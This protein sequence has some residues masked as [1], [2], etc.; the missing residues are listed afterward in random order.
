MNPNLGTSTI[1]IEANTETVWAVLADE[2]VDLAAWSP[3]V[4][5]SGPNPATPEGING[6]RYGGRVAEVEGLGHIDVRLTAYDADART[7]SYTVDAE[8]I[9]PFIERLSNTWTVTADGVD[10]CTVLTE[11]A[12]TIAE[13]MAGNE[14]AS[15]AVDT[16]LA[17]GTGASTDLKTY[18]EARK[19]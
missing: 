7:L 14:Q 18:I 2:F 9:P 1:T 5:S 15:K 8:K 16:M 17:A 6:S 11:V 12:I 13:A 3:G 4:I 10:R 19:G